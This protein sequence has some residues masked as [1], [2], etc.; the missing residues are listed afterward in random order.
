MTQIGNYIFLLS[1]LFW[2]GCVES[3][4]QPQ[5]FYSGYVTPIT[6]SR[7]SLER[8]VYYASPQPIKYPGKIYIKGKYLYVNERA[9]GIHIIDVSNPASPSI[10]GFLNIIGNIDIAIKDDALY[11]DNAVD[12]ITI[13]LR[14]LPNVNVTSRTRNIFPY[15]PTPNNRYWYGRSLDPDRVIVGWKDTIN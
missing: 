4:S 7:D 14:S 15:L 11:A 1:A 13:D 3:T 8:S 2:I 10:I 5:T 9:R 6:I 12:L